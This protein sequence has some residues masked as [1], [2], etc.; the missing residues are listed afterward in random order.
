V[1]FH[2]CDDHQS[3]ALGRVV[4][5]TTSIHNTILIFSCSAAAAIINGRHVLAVS[6]AAAATVE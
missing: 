5:I 1:D 6:A 3:R 4:F 2:V